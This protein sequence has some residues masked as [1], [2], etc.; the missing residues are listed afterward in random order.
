[1][2]PNFNR[3]EDKYKLLSN[4]IK[5]ILA[6]RSLIYIASVTRPDISWAVNI[7]RNPHVKMI[8]EQLKE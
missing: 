7:L 3:L 4:N 5:Y 6:V 8:G 2:E 1:M